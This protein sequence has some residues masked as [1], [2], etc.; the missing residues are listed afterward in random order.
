MAQT[1]RW[2]SVQH[3]GP[4]LQSGE[5]RAHSLG[6]AWALTGRGLA[7]SLPAQ[8]LPSCCTS[9][10]SAPSPGLCWRPCTCTG[11]SPRCAMSTPAPC[12]STT[13]WAGVCL[14]SSQVPPAPSP[15]LEVYIPRASVHLYATFFRVHPRPGGPTSL[16][17]GPSSPQASLSFNSVPGSPTQGEGPLGWRG[18]HG[19]RVDRTLP[20][21]HLALGAHLSA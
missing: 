6:V 11:R 13:C 20:P 10:T 3:P 16:C 18:W 14:P 4:P 7:L 9:C 2:S 12:D 8:S 15:G 5:S 19:Q 17:S 1:P 21:L